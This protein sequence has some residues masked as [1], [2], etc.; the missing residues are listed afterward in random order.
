LEYVIGSLMV[1][2]LMAGHQFAHYLAYGQEW[3]EFRNS[4][5]ALM[6]HHFGATTVK[7]IRVC[8]VA[9]SALIAS[10][11]PVGYLVS[12]LV[13]EAWAVWTIRKKIVERRNA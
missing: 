8:E 3:V 13:G 12:A 1:V 5:L 9:A 10:W 7:V 11:Y 2:A 4:S 6:E